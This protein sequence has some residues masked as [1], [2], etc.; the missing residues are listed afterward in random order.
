MA[1]PLSYCVVVVVVFPFDGG[2]TGG[3]SVSYSLVVV[4]SVTWWVVEQP[5]RHKIAKPAQPA[6]AA[7]IARFI[8]VTSY[9]IVQS[10][11]ASRLHWRSE[12]P[13]DWSASA[14]LEMVPVAQSL[15]RD[16]ARELG[17]A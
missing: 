1:V 9:P 14:V 11:S 3:V 12:N 6:M 8:D 4:V 15:S 17:R 10:R 13:H 2:G 5:T 16:P 7:L